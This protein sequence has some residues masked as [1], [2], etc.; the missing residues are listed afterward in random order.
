MPKL[1]ALSTFLP[2]VTDE[3][4]KR[5]AEKKAGEKQKL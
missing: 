2:V 4:Q 1:Q 5:A 3:T